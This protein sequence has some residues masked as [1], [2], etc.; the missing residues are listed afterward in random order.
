MRGLEGKCGKGDGVGVEDR[1]WGT[2]H[3][4]G[5]GRERQGG[6][7]RRGGRDERLGRI[8]RY[9]IDLSINVATCDSVLYLTHPRSPHN[10]LS[11]NTPPPPPPPPYL[12]THLLTLTQPAVPSPQ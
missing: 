9:S 10:D 11:P 3:W 8:L 6:S 4:R 12:R 5:G 1:G 2:M 7:I